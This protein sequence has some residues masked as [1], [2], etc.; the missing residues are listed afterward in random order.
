MYRKAE[1]APLQVP[2]RHLDQRLGLEPVLDGLVHRGEE[3]ADIE[4]V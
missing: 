3:A 2:E 4:G 1:R